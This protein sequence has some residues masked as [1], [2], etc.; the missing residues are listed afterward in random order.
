MDSEE[1]SDIIEGSTNGIFV[2]VEGVGFQKKESGSYEI[3]TWDVMQP[4]LNSFSMLH[5]GVNNASSII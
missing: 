3:Y 5:T 2:G 4:E 1:T